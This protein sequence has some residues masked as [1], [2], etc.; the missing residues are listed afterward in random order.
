M[1]MIKHIVMFKLKEAANTSDVLSEVQRRLSA[2]TD[3][4]PTLRSLDVGINS[5]Q[6]NPANCELVLICE[7]DDMA[8]LEEYRVHPVHVAFGKFITPLREQRTCID[9]EH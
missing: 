6:A 2:F 3:G 9:Y 8:G 7:F 4:I 1:K 5:P